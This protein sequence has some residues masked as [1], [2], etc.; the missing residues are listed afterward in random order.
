M[1][2]LQRVQAI[3]LAVLQTGAAVFMM[4]DPDDGFYVIAAIMS[5]SLLL[6]GCG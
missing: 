1:T 3:A 2:K 5:I 6:L 4:I